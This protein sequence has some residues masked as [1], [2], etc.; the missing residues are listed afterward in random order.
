MKIAV[1]LSGQPRTFKLTYKPLLRFLEGF[2]VDFYLHS[3]VHNGEGYFSTKSDVPVPGGKKELY[4]ELK[5][6]YSPKKILVQNYEEAPLLGYVDSRY[7]EDRLRSMYYGM[8]SVFGLLQSTKDYDKKYDAVLWTRFDIYF[9]E[10]PRLQTCPDFKLRERECMF[11]HIGYTPSPGGL[12]TCDHQFWCHP[13]C[14]PGFL[15]GYSYLVDNILK[16][17]ESNWDVGNMFIYLAMHNRFRIS[18]MHTGMGNVL[19]RPCIEKAGITLES[20]GDLDVMYAVSDMAINYIPTYE[21]VVNFYQSK[22]DTR[23]INPAYWKRKDDEK[24]RT[25]TSVRE[26]NKST[27]LI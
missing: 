27:K 18:E 24:K 9:V 2:D 14:V 6:V 25:S 7:L 4:R 21:E 19:V 8:S 20:E 16:Y 1:C 11:G 10:P 13:T 15:N 22:G 17:D 3:W 23:F 5:K 26:G 12:I